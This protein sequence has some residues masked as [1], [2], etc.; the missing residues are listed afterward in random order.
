LFS[1]DFLVWAFI[2]FFMPIADEPALNVM[3]QQTDFGIAGVGSVSHD[4]FASSK[5]ITQLLQI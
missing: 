1:L 4:Y 5:F 3:V 2:P